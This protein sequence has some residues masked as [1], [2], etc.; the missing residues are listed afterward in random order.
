VKAGDRYNRL[1]AIEP[2]PKRLTNGGM[3]LF[4]C[5]C[6]NEIVTRGASVKN[7]HTRSCGCL[8][9]EIV[10]SF[11]VKHGGVS[12]GKPTRLY[13]TWMGMIERCRRP[14]NEFFHRYGGRGISVC[15]EWRDFKT[16]Q[17]WAMA[18]GYKNN[19]YI[20]RIDNDGNY[21]PNNCRWATMVEN[22]G[23]TSKTHNITID[24][25]THCAAEWARRIGSGDRNVCYWIKH[26]GEEITALIIKRRME[27]LK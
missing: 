27:G 18:N 25:E 3:W 11:S 19:L 26:Y 10:R 14:T 6:G 12:N 24:G 1:T 17:H 4:R 21:E 16:F 22:A 2:R 13:K 23:H 20:D 9:T 5:D 15:D 7:G 8:H